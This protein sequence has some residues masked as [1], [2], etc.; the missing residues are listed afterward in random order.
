[1]QWLVLVRLR[2]REFS[3]YRFPTRTAFLNDEKGLLIYRRDL[4][5]DQQPKSFTKFALK[6]CV[7]RIID[8]PWHINFLL[9]KLCIGFVVQH[10]EGLT[11][12]IK[13][14]LD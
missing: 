9:L 14:L 8:K 4:G 3:A 10:W 2:V 13:L 7:S 11:L 12:R 1:M 6:I 5:L